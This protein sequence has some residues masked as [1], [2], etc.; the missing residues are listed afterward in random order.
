MMLSV[1]VVGAGAAFSDQSKIKNTEAVD[2][3]TALNIIGGYPDGSFKPEG[4]ITRAE[5]TKMICVALNGGKEPAVS[6]NA[7]PTFSDVRT[8][9][10]AA[11]A[12]GYIESCV[13]QGIVSGVG[14]GKFAPA[15]NVTGTQLAK[16]LLVALGYNS[17]I[18]KFTGNAWAT[19]VNVVATQK[20]LYDGLETMDVSTALTRDNAAQ[21]I[22][23]ALQAVEVEYKY[24]LDGSNGNLSSKAQVVDKTHR[25]SGTDVD[26]TLLWD[27]FSAT[28][29]EGVLNGSGKYAAGVKADKRTLAS[30]PGT[31]YFSMVAEKR[32]DNTITN[33]NGVATP[34]DKTI[35]YADVDLTG[36]VGEYV[37]VLL[38]KNDKVY[39]VYSMA[40]KNTVV[41]TTADLLKNQTSD[42]IKIDGTKYDLESDFAVYGG[43]LVNTSANKVKFVDNDK[44][45]KFDVAIVVPVGVAKVT[46][47][48]SDS[49]TLNKTLGDANLKSASQKKADIIINGDIAK[50]DYVVYQK[51]LY[52]DKDSIT[53][54]DLVEGK[55]SGVKT[56]EWQI[57]GTWYKI[58]GDTT[59]YAP[60]SY[61]P[62]SGDTVKMV[63]LGK[64]IYYVE[65]TDGANSAKDVVM[66]VNWV[67]K[68]GLDK[69]KGIL[70]FSDG[71]KKTVEVKKNSGTLSASEIGNLF[72][73]KVD[74]DDV[75]ELTPAASMT[76]Y[77]WTAG[78]A[79]DINLVD[80]VM[81]ASTS[82]A[83]ADDA[84]VYLISKTGNAD[85]NTEAK[86][87]TGKELKG[88]STGSTNATIATTSRGF[89]VSKSN[90]IKKA[91]I[92]GVT[93][94]TAAD[95]LDNVTGQSSANYG[96]LVDD[97]YTSTENNKDYVNFPVWNGKE[98]VTYKWEKSS[99]SMDSFKKHAVIGY[100]IVGDN[101]IKNVTVVNATKAALT[102]GEGTKDVQFNATGSTY[103][104]TG[105]T[106]VIYV[107]GSADEAKDIGVAGGS[108]S[109]ALEPSEGVYVQNVKYILKS[110]SSDEI[111]LLVVDVNNKL[112]DRETGNLT[113]TNSANKPVQISVNDKISE[114]VV[115][116]GDNVEIK[117]TGS[118]DITVTISGATTTVTG[119]T[120]GAGSSITVT[121]N[122]S[123]ALSVTIN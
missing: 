13:A 51:D 107:N 108:I 89:Y 79:G 95:T 20:G 52:N 73:Y 60:G 110:G 37:K 6:T 112:E 87:I 8:N 43:S 18:E 55:I 25:E 2:A 53:K 26:T 34:V 80:D 71:S 109:N 62:A 9:A 3:C 22:W 45:G 70:L 40:D 48:G 98:T 15:G 83:I 111:E 33:S 29:Y 4:N 76:D 69:Q 91:T 78:A 10:N 61:T 103:K 14:A 58:F 59:T 82:Y 86:V 119:Q 39:G 50:D 105:D 84:I 72:T 46:F 19:N 63:A 67:D 85:A 114:G 32:N 47:V 97:A 65:K 31:D 24:T 99:V 56:G 54:A 17:D 16:M 92:I 5:A 77:D 49:V 101:T 116:A 38:G 90:G 64:K 41:S 74:N 121:V 113:V 115:A 106:T 100:D 27:K 88:Y 7:T 36:F 93:L 102:G 11:W 96:Y 23:N 123:K 66:L 118:S 21:M 94:G 68:S 117:N 75:Y 1:M 44:N 28:T 35:K 57:E 81:G 122:A 30:A 42:S 12:E 120:I 104:I